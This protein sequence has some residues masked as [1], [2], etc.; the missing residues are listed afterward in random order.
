MSNCKACFQPTERKNLS[1]IKQHS[2]QR[3]ATWIGFIPQSCQIISKWDWLQLVFL[4]FM[5]FTWTLAEEQVI[6]RKTCSFQKKEGKRESAKRE[7]QHSRRRSQW[8]REEHVLM[9]KSWSKTDVSLLR[10]REGKPRAL[11]GQPV[12]CNCWSCDSGLRFCS[13]MTDSL[14]GWLYYHT[15][16]NLRREDRKLVLKGVQPQVYTE[17]IVFFPAIFLNICL[18][19]WL[20]FEIDYLLLS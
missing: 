7:V 14:D 15:R 13:P 17:D 5:A 11:E 6:L 18:L 1:E 12:K 10:Q 19:T 4:S 8:S 2:S 20:N 3:R 16:M 9:W